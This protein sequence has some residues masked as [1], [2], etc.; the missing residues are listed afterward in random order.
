MPRDHPLQE[1]DVNDGF[2]LLDPVRQADAVKAL[3]AI[4]PPEAVFY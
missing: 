3:R 2:R 1:H 4:L